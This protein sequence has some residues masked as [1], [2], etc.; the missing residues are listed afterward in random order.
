MSFVDELHTAP[1]IELQRT[2]QDL[3]ALEN[4]ASH[5]TR[6]ELHKEPQKLPKKA[7]LM[8]LHKAP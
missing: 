8:E 7:L 5:S 3:E 4:G 6:A 1:Q 2:I